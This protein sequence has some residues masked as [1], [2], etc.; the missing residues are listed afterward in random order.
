MGGDREGHHIAV[1]QDLAHA[2]VTDLPSD[3]VLRATAFGDLLTPLPPR[4][5]AEDPGTWFVTPTL[6]PRGSDR[7]EADMVDA[8]RAHQ[9]AV[10]TSLGL[11]RPV[12]ALAIRLSADDQRR[13]EAAH[14]RS[15]WV[16]TLDQGIGPEFFEDA[17]SGNPHFRR[18]LLDYAP[19]FL[20]GLGRK[21]AVT[22]TH[23]G[24]VRRIL[25]DALR[26]L[27]IGQD[28]MNR[29]PVRST[30]SCSCPAGLRSGCSVTPLS[31][32]RR[33]ALPPSWR[34]WTSAVS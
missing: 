23:H 13:F 25:G 22:T 31:P 10:A 28:P 7:I 2:E 8:H 21:L 29:S 20:E 33:S 19:D 14:D 4:R 1:V 9:M 5:A 26:D 3:T 6:K 12:P 32:L 27:G 11:A 17:D 15:D 24:E 16:V 30:V 34:T 18:Y